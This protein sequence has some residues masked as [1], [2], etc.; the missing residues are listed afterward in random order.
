MPFSDRLLVAEAVESKPLTIRKE[1]VRVFAADPHPVVLYGLAHM[2]ASDPDIVFD[3]FAN[4][5]KRLHLALSL[6]HAD[7][8]LI[9]WSLLEILSGNKEDYLRRSFPRSR[10]LVLHSAEERI[11]CLDAYRCGADG[12]VD[13]SSS[14]AVLRRAIRRVHNGG[15]WVEENMAENL[16]RTAS[17]HRTQGVKIGIESLT[18]REREVISLVCKSMRNKEIATQLNITETT[19]WHHLTS[20]F[21]KLGVT[22]RLSLVMLAQERIGEL[23]RSAPQQ[24]ASSFRS[25]ESN[26]LRTM[27]SRI[28][29]SS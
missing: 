12:T 19:V 11:N 1:K 28:N 25:L 16:I 26:S 17:T 29:C 20:V 14:P 10:I 18:E 13:K 15:L 2:F 8:L 4:S 5:F 21:S 9:A 22:S 6:R 3:G 27:G 7:V 24:T 23:C